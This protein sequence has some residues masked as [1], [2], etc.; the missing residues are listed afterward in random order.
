MAVL[1]NTY[2]AEVAW[3]Q[4]VVQIAKQNLVKKNKIAAGTL[5]NSV[6]FDV[7]PQTLIIEFYYANEGKFVESGRRPNSKMPPIT[8]IA[9]WAQQKRL[10]Q[11]RD[12]KGRY[13]SNEARAFLLARAIAIKGI[14]P[15]P[16]FTD[17]I[18]EATVLL[19][20]ELEENLAKDMEG[21][22]EI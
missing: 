15:Y 1:Q 11:F 4:R 5:Y 19:Y 9:K 3:A 17:A 21:K 12:K 16:F 6:G 14:K 20:K 7:D 18:D 13:I 10:P 22:L 8:A 2:N